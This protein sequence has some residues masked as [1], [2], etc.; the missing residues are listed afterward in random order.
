MKLMRRRHDSE[1]EAAAA[2]VGRIGEI[3]KG[4]EVALAAAGDCLAQLGVIAH[5]V[6]AL[7]QRLG[8]TALTHS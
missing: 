8:G 1:L 2:L 4:A 3:A 7:A 5:A 6:A